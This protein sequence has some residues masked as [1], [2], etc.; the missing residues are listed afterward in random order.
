MDIKISI[1]IPT[2][3]RSDFLLRAIDSLLHQ[4]YSNVEIIVIDDNVS[5]SEFRLLTEQKMEKYKDNKKI[6]Y[7]KNK[8]NLGGALARN[9]GI[10]KATGEFVTFL[11]DDD[12][13]LPNKVENQLQYMIK[14]ELDL[15]FTNVRI[16]NTN[17]KLVDFREHPY[18]KSFSNDELLKQHIMHHLTPTATYMFKREALISIGGFDDVKVGQE[19]MLMLKAI[20]SNLKIGYLPVADII[21]YIHPGERISIGQNKIEK[22][23]ELFDFKQKYMKQL[24]F[25]QRQYVKF[26][27]HAVMTVV[28]K[29][30]RKPLVSINHLV[31]AVIS[32]PIDCIEE[33]LYFSKKLI[34]YK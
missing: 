5:N 33:F 4:T 29:R 24:T 30:S 27:Y 3:K 19:F 25:R 9:V 26:R 1:V 28:G 22:E 32:S 17:N 21:Q 11:D 34:K 6:I 10:Y 14:N 15:S 16:H 7:I 23:K 12:I 20:E 18:I 31:K 2:Y 13:Y 8:E